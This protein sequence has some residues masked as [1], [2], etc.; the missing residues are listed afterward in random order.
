M[1]C[2]ASWSVGHEQYIEVQCPNCYGSTM[3]YSNRCYLCSTPI[4]PDVEQYIGHIERR[5]EYANEGVE[6]AA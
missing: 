1:L 2:K 6:N 4:D 3:V 5:L